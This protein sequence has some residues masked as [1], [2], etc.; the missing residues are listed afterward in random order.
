VLEGA[1]R[2]LAAPAAERRVRRRRAAAAGVPKMTDAELV[3]FSEHLYYEIEQLFPGR[4]RFGASAARLFGAPVLRLN[5]AVV[6]TGRGSPPQRRRAAAF[7]EAWV[8][9]SGKTNPMSAHETQGGLRSLPPASPCSSR[10]HKGARL[11][12]PPRYSNHEDSIRV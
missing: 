12:V 1:E 5:Y 2:H 7:S 9:W 8:L 4:E 3:A 10:T 6:R 11:G